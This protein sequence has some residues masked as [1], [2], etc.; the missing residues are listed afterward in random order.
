M[1]K[2]FNVRLRKFAQAVD[3]I[4]T[5]KLFLQSARENEEL[6]L[7]LNRSQLLEKGIDSTGKSLGKYKE[8]TK[9][10]KRKKGQPTEHIT[11]YDEGKFQGRMVLKAKAIPIFIDSSDSKTPLLK[12]KYGD[13]ILGLTTR[14]KEAFKQATLIMYRKKVHKEIEIL[15][16][17]ILL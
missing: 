5:E 11:L 17:K 4:N 10:R 1:K 15:K 16:E 2:D 6:A 12:E 14:N 8:S 9:A 3:N 13:S 7:D